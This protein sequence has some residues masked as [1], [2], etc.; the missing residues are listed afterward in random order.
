MKESAGRATREVICCAEAIS[1]SLVV[2]KLCKEIT[3]INTRKQ[4]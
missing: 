3:E 1:G 2:H 4:I